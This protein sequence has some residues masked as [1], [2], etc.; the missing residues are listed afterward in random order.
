MPTG[1]GGAMTDPR[2]QWTDKAAIGL[3]VVALA[4]SFWT[5]Q[6]S[7]DKASDA[8][9]LAHSNEDRLNRQDVQQFASRVYLGEAPEDMCAEHG[10]DQDGEPC[11]AVVNASAVEVVNVWVEGSD[12][13]RI[14]IQ[15]VQRCHVY[16]LEPGFDPV[17][18]YFSDPVGNWHRSYGKAL[19]QLEADRDMTPPATPTTDDGR[20][21]WDGPLDNCP[22]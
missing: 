2:P 13:R 9:R 6:V 20:S 12:G 22:G 3:S 5:F 10:D 19:E 21:N 8:L 4:G 1:H 14:V 16:N 18:L 11:R 7:D 15:G 17:Q